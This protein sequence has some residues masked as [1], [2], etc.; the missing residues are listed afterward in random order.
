MGSSG[1]FLQGFAYHGMNIV[2]P[3]SI[4]IL[5][6]TLLPGSQV[7]KELPWDWY[8][9]NNFLGFALCSAYSPPDNESEDR[10]GDGDGDGYFCTFK[11]LSTFLISG[12][13]HEI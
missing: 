7:T 10:D 5:E 2:I 11:Y 12:R 9:N 13:Q 4:G 3:E 1:L 8:E 6:G